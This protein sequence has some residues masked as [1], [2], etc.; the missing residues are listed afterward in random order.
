MSPPHYGIAQPE[1]ALGA[2]W[3]VAL[4]VVQGAGA[5]S[6]RLKWSYNDRGIEKGLVMIV[7][8]RG[9]TLRGRAFTYG[10][11]LM[12]PELRPR[13]AEALVVPVTCGSAAFVKPI[14]DSEP[15]WLKGLNGSRKVRMLTFPSD[16]LVGRC[17]ALTIGKRLDPPPG[18]TDP[19]LAVLTISELMPS[20]LRF[21]SI[22]DSLSAD[23]R[24]RRITPDI[25][26]TR[27]AE[28]R[29]SWQRT[30]LSGQ[31]SLRL[32][33]GLHN[34]GMVVVVGATGDTLK[35]RAVHFGAETGL[36]TLQ[37]E[38]ADAALIPTSCSRLELTEPWVPGTGRSS[39][40][41]TTQH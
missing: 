4:W 39:D 9:D 23:R 30:T 6:L 36:P 41:G 7:D 25:S 31:D 24:D 3:P 37:N 22:A 1:K 20:V 35:G 2:V 17:F 26:G 27:V 5:D 29:A 28:W 8:L 12:I 10:D 40:A 21:D 11:A 18:N 13:T 15:I 16:P 34:Q 19:E 33:W 14:A 32:V 38:H